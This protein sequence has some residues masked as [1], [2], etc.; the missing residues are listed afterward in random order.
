MR[1]R[2]ITEEAVDHVLANFHTS[3]PAS[4][5][6]V[7]IYLDDW[8]GRALRVYVVRDSDPLL[9]MTVAWED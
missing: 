5:K 1:Q 6:D 8:E 3:R 9:V 2:G 4:S 7:V